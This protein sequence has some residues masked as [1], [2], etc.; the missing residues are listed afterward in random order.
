[1]A[2]APGQ[3]RPHRRAS[4]HVSAEPH[5]SRE[6]PLAIELAGLPWRSAVDSRRSPGLPTHEHAAKQ[7]HAMSSL[8]VNANAPVVRSLGLERMLLFSDAVIAIAL[9]L[10][11]LD[12]PIPVA[13]SP[14]GLLADL[15]GEEARSYV[16]FLVA[17]ALIGGSWIA[18]HELFSSIVNIDGRLMALNLMILLGFVLVPWATEAVST[19]P[20]GAGLAVF[21]AVMTLLTGSLSALAWYAANSSLL[22][23]DAPA[24]LLARTL[25]LVGV[26]TAMFALSI[27]LA[28]ALGEFVIVLWPLVYIGV[29]TYARRSKQFAKG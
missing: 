10:L 9:T 5:V 29:T 17:F 27:P 12:L 21:A 26:P 24:S 15:A 20:G 4:F 13:D 3:L 25:I 11:A 2:L 28:F 19:S 14:L 23:P 18:H 7:S 16:A 6:T 1:V 8:I 22:R